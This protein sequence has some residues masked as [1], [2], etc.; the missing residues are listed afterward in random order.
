MR[1]HSSH[2]FSQKN[3]EGQEFYF[4]DSQSE[5]PN[6]VISN[7]EEKEV[8]SRKKG[9]GRRTQDPIM[10]RDMREWVVQRIIQYQLMP[11]R[12][13]VINRAQ[14]YKNSRFLASKGWCD[15]FL[16]RNSVHFEKHLIK[17][18]PFGEL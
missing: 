2:S 14:I 8:K 9:A 10:E 12:S 11:S 6:L 1:S 7:P 13:E 3:L 18:K 15:K 17:E 16:K 4:E 5:E